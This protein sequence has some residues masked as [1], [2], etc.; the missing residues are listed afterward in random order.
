[1]NIWQRKLLAFLH[2]PPHKA[3]DISGHEPAREIFLRQAG[4]TD[5]ASWQEF[6]RQA[7]W[8]ASAADRFPLF[9]SSLQSPFGGDHPFKHPLGGSEL[10]V[11]EFPSP[12]L[13]ATWLQATQPHGPGTLDAFEGEER[14]R[15]NFFLHWRR[16]P[17]E[18]AREPAERTE[19]RWRSAY[20]PA[21]TRLPDHPIWLHNSVVSALEGAGRQ[22]AFL[23]FQ[24]GPVQ[25]FIAQARS[26]RDLWSGSYL[27]SWLMAHAIKTVTDEFGPDA[28]I[29]PFLRAQP[30][31]D[32]LHRDSIYEKVKYGGDSL[33]K[34]MKPH[35][36][37]ILVPNLPNKFLALVPADKG[38]DVADRACKEA[39]AELQRIADASWTWINQRHPL[40]SDWRE[41]FKGQIEAFLQ[42][43]WQCHPWSLE[44]P[45][46]KDLRDLFGCEGK[47]LA[48]RPNPGLLWAR[49]YAK[50]DALHAARR[51]T[52]DFE[53]WM[54]ADKH[55]NGASKDTLSGKEEIV[56]SPEEWWDK[57]PPGSELARLFKG[58]DR[59][60]A[61]N[62]VKRVW[63]RAYLDE[64]WKLHPE[65][66]VR[67]E[68]LPDIAAAEWLEAVRKDVRDALKESTGDFD[69][70]LSLCAA[71]H[72]NAAA[73][74]IRVAEEEPSERHIEDWLEQT[75]PEAFLDS[76]WKKRIQGEKEKEE[77]CAEVVGKLRDL[78]ARP[79]IGK[80]PVY[81]A[82]IAL[83]GDEMGKW[84]SGEK[85]P[86][87]AG[88]FSK[89]AADVFAKIVGQR[90]RPLSPSYHLQ[91]S[92][93]LAN[94]ALY[95]VRPI[96]ESFSGQVIYAGG[97]D[98]L[99]M[100]PAA[101]ALECAAA[102]RDAFRGQGR[103]EGV[104]ESC[105]SHG[106]FVRLLQP[107]GE[108]PTGPL[109]VPGPRA[110]VSAGIAIGHCHAPL[111]NLVEAA[112][113]AE[114]LAKKRYGRSAFAVSLFKRSGETIQWGTK[115]ES[116]ALELLNETQELTQKGYLTGRFPYALAELLRP[117][118][119][120]EWRI[121]KTDAFD[122][123]EVF[124]R[125]F[126]HVAGR[127]GR[128][129]QGTQAAKEDFLRI[130][131]AYLGV[132][133]NESDMTCRGRRLDDFLGP[134]LTH[135][136]ISRRGGE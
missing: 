44:A 91:F 107:K 3:L 25:D 99:A 37:E 35:E 11:K 59:L 72:R 12:D 77:S 40:K 22:P 127:Q 119:Q 1:M 89:E 69:N 94:F 96:V 86:E 101:R 132:A 34:R 8:R 88:Q 98:V 47:D 103:Q 52:R 32:L 29:F 93:A 6:D 24:I 115:W 61:I 53:S 63:H 31:F 48:Y 108:Q 55:R 5:P 71:I 136:F 38:A 46:D 111:Q 19:D 83:D 84:I 67:F 120:D 131:A 51:N 130:A 125:E 81:A 54:E 104:Y 17:V 50:T 92:E 7:D 110:D 39:R 16:W 123:F 66:T 43:T 87:L 102:L 45:T 10:T 121:E 114:G 49:H 85:T 74:G 41:R 73:Y 18:T 62:M 64:I 112:R 42:I 65:K 15:V 68:S 113:R 13:L 20:Q 95:L 82:V 56:G 135:A 58:G 118:A 126:E 30:L 134:F 124:P 116:R 23:L 133:A 9:R 75:A 109:V 26:T 76:E 100:V 28:V 21:D 78:Y 27:L 2:D 128:W 105:G 60:G 36:N 97:D 122:P 57:V 90:R 79:N 80:P 4:F 106:G 129:P 33:W 70:L 14:D 117:Y